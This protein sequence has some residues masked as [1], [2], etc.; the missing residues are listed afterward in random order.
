MQLLALG[1][2]VIAAPDLSGRGNLSFACTLLRP[3]CIGTPKETQGMSAHHSFVIPV[4]LTDPV[5]TCDSM[6][7][8]RVTLTRSVHCRQIPI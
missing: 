2:P 1:P 6:R 8:L 4:L 5:L 7:I 3:D